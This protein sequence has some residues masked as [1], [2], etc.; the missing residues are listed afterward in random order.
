M[1]GYSLTHAR[2]TAGVKLTALRINNSMPAIRSRRT[3]VGVCVG[4][5][6]TRTETCR[7]IRRKVI[8][9]APL[10]FDD[11]WRNVKVFIS[12]RLGL[13]TQTI[14][15]DCYTT[16]RNMSAFDERLIGCCYRFESSIQS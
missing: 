5:F 7:K 3:N 6:A 11:S 14:L 15:F 16:I 10:P 4:V 13:P 9:I 8:A 12:D 2:P 1:A